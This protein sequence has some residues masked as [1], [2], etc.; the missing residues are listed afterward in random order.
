MHFISTYGD[1][2]ALSFENIVRVASIS[3]CKNLL[4]YEHAGSC[5]A[6]GSAEIEKDI[7]CHTFS[8]DGSRFALLTADKKL[9]LWD[10]VS[11]SRQADRPIQRRPTCI[12]FTNSTADTVLIADKSGDVYKYNLASSDPPADEKD[13]SELILG[14]LSMLLDLRVTSDDKY[15]LTSDRDEKIRVSYLSHPYVIKSYC[16]SHT[17]LVS[18]MVLI[19]DGLLVSSSADGSIRSWD[20]LNGK[21]LSVVNMSSNSECKDTSII[22]QVVH[23]NGTLCFISEKERLLSFLQVDQNGILSDLQKI[24][25]EFLPKRVSFNESGLL[26]ISDDIKPIRVYERNAEKIFQEKELR[27]FTDLYSSMTSFLTNGASSSDT[28][29]F[30]ELLK[31]VKRSCSITP[32][33]T[34]RS[35]EENVPSKKQKVEELKEKRC[36]EV[37]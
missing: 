18:S 33:T 20:F 13:G 31:G 2:L 3:T 36:V 15:I 16:L 35:V 27:S 25:T 32:E 30:T 17:K 37:S 23:H 12:T 28:S 34:I 5:I 14:H 22:S 7:L 9:V 4:S 24:Q 1:L 6:N 26:I 19:N 29:Y 11:W 8:T 10:V 21:Q